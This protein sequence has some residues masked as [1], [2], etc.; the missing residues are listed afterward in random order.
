MCTKIY[1]HTHTHTH[2]QTHTHVRA[3]I[4]THIHI[5]MDVNWS[6][7][8]SKI[9]R[10]K[11]SNNRI[12]NTLCIYYEIPGNSTFTQNEMGCEQEKDIVGHTI[13]ESLWYTTIRL[14]S[15]VE[16]A[17]SETDVLGCYCNNPGKRQ[18]GSDQGIG[19][20]GS[21]EKWC[22]CMFVGTYTYKYIHTHTKICWL[23]GWR[24]L[25]K[26]KERI[27]DGPPFLAWDV[28]NG[29]F[30]LDGYKNWI[31]KRFKDLSKVHQ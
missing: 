17:G 10:N 31:I 4:H 13:K 11:S 3:H 23:T 2:T 18:C 25:K 12:I 22:D 6:I 26:K 14:W 20:C 7:I 24:I 28:N 19:D 5:W 16:K 9:L 30:L 1:M 21:G 27:K 29:V 8:I 15:N